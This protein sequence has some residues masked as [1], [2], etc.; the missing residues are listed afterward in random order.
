MAKKFGGPVAE[1]INKVVAKLTE[2]PVL[3]GLLGKAF[4]QITYTGRRSGQTFTTPVNYRR[5]GDNYLIGVAMPDKK[6]WWRNFSGE[7]A[8]ITLRIDGKDIPGH[9]TS[10]KNEKGAVTVLVTPTK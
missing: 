4:A 3:S 2:L 9:A 8:P 10:R 7:G 1:G 6:Q 5:K